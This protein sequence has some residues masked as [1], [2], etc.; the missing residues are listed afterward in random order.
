MSRSFVKMCCKRVAIPCVRQAP[1][2]TASGANVG[3]QLNPGPPEPAALTRFERVCRE[4]GP[5]FD[6]RG[7]TPDIPQAGKA[8]FPEPF[9]SSGG[10]IR[11]RDLRVMRSN[12]GLR[13]FSDAAS[14][15]SQV[16]LARLRFAQVGTSC[17]TSAERT[18]T[19]PFRPRS[20]Y[21]LIEL[22]AAAARMNASSSV[23]LPKTI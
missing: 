18:R 15:A 19:T 23:S 12:G 21:G 7:H 3:A 22:A 16:M 10:G 14:A 13:A 20:R 4:I 6:R 8:P 9:C 17:G 11:T 5:V 1:I 2:A